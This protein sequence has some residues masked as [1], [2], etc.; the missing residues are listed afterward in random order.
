[1]LGV[2]HELFFW[3]LFFWAAGHFRLWTLQ[4][5]QE[6]CYYSKT[7]TKTYSYKF[8]IKH[9]C[10]IL[11]VYVCKQIILYL[12]TENTIYDYIFDKIYRLI[13]KNK[14]NVKKPKY[15]RYNK[16]NPKNKKQN[17]NK[18]KKTSSFLLFCW[19]LSAGNIVVFTR[20]PLP[21]RRT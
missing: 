17:Q 10:V 6:E 21:Q 12:K 13:A 20:C 2:N 1:M 8:R 19:S 3:N 9:V 7:W 15:Y 4:Q 18:T 14:V 11:S 16:K 5:E